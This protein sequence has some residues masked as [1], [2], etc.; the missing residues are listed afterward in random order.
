MTAARIGEQYG[1]DENRLQA[2]RHVGMAKPVLERTTNRGLSIQRGVHSPPPVVPVVESNAPVDRGA[3]CASR[4][5]RFRGQETFDFRR[6]RRGDPSAAA[7]PTSIPSKSPE[8][9]GRFP[10]AE[11]RMRTRERRAGLPVFRSF[12]GTPGMRLPRRG[13]SADLENFFV[14]INRS[15]RNFQLIRHRSAGLAAFPQW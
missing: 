11:I 15:E 4:L 1:S 5:Q 7:P 9:S 14:R 3:A 6:T 2:S 12:C 13:V 8:F 10:R